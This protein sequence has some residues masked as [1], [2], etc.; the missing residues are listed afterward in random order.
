M[1]LSGLGNDSI[2]LE[3]PAGSRERDEDPLACAQRELAEETGFTAK[4]WERLLCA[5]AEPVRST[6]TMTAY[7]AYDAKCTHEQNL[8]PSECIEVELAPIADVHAMLREGKIDSLA[9]IA[10]A[11]AALERIGPTP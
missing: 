11:Y 3:L 10:T 2:S 1:R 9:C 5:S 4:R 8:D 7:I 6:A